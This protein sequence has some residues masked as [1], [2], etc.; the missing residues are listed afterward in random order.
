MVAALARSSSVPRKANSRRRC[1]RVMGATGLRRENVLVMRWEWFDS[2]R[3]TPLARFGELF[4]TY[5]RW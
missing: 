4:Y 2:E 1:I 5:A 3:A